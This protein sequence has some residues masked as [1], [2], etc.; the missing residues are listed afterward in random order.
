[1][2]DKVTLST[3]PAPIVLLV[4]YVYIIVHYVFFVNSILFTL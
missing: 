2:S 3:F 4:F 1:M